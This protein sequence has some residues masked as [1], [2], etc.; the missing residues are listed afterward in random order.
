[1]SITGTTNPTI[2]K[3][4]SLE[5][6]KNRPTTLISSG[7]K[8]EQASLIVSKFIQYMKNKHM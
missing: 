2:Y 1:M 8:K 6:A 5:N 4:I 7:T 3:S